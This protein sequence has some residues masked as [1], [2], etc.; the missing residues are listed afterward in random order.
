MGGKHV[1]PAEHKG[2]HMKQYCYYHAPIGKL[3]I[4]GTDGKLETI[5][6]PNAI[7]QFEITEELHYN[8]DIFITISNQLS[9]YFAGKRQNFEMELL[10]QGTEFQ[11]KVW[12]EL[13]NVPFGQTTSYGD[14]ACRIGNSKACRAVGMANSKNPIPIVIPCHRII[15]KD[16]SLTGFGGGLDIKRKLLELE[17]ISF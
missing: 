6:F 13:Q 14:V 12:Q 11:K 15:G 1:I 7:D 5:L 10:P 9:E 8:E 2:S 16:G 17:G 4:G 3:L